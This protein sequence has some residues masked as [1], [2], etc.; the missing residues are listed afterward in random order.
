MIVNIMRFQVHI[1]RSKAR[2]LH[3]GA[4]N[5]LNSIISGRYGR[6]RSWQKKLHKQVRKG[7]MA[8]EKRGQSQ[9]A[10]QGEDTFDEELQKRYW[11]LL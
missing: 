5:M 2:T 3:V 7:I 9:C 6:V 8:S 11:H 10:I 1:N 4:A